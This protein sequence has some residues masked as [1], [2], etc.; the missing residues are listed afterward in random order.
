MMQPLSDCLNVDEGEAVTEE[1]LSAR[2][3][4]KKKVRGA[5][6]SRDVIDDN[7][8]ATNSSTSLL[9]GCTMSKDMDECVHRNIRYPSMCILPFFELSRL[10]RS[11]KKEKIRQSFM[12]SA[13]DFF[14]WGTI[15]DTLPE[16]P[17]DD[18]S[19]QW[20][21]HMKLPDSYIFQFLTSFIEVC[22]D[23]TCLDVIAQPFW[24]GVPGFFLYLQLFF[25]VFQY[26]IVR[27][28]SQ[29]ILRKNGEDTSMVET[30]A[31]ECMSICSSFFRSRNH[32]MINGT[33]L[34]AA[35]ELL[36]SGCHRNILFDI[37]NGDLL[38]LLSF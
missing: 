35:I 9:R 24:Q 20:I 22:E 23:T 34:N 11:H 18:A 17:T 36:F 1:V 37:I 29:F 16:V 6:E 2:H 28:S 13:P 4:F 15:A 27:K 19:F 32:F 21:E 38:S 10:I 25:S 30:A 12:E 5:R 31:T 3:A 14:A 33:V 26:Y 7:P 8:Y